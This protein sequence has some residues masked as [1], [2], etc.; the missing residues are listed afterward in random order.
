MTS[1]RQLPS[2][3]TSQ[4]LSGLFMRSDFFG[5]SIN[6]SGSFASWLGSD[7]VARITRNNLGQKLGNN[8][9]MKLWR[10]GLGM[11]PVLQIIL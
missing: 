3:V 7:A 8:H 9:W 4:K 5:S 6:L 11:N 10:V 1:T 2:L